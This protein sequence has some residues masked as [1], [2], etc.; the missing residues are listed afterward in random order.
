MLITNF[1][2]NY[3][4]IPR[5]GSLGAAI[6]TDVAIL[7]YFVLLFIAVNKEFNKMIHKDKHV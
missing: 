4:L 2:L 3:L 6:A 5:Y 1:V 7:P